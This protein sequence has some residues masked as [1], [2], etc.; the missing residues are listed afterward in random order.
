MIV[1]W[2]GV[3]ERE[4]KCAGLSS[5]LH[6]QS[7]TGSNIALGG[8]KGEIWIDPAKL[9]K[10]P[11]KRCRLCGVKEARNKQNGKSNILRFGETCKKCR[12]FDR[13]QV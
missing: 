6:Q 8:K 3:L 4:G 11:L 1:V 10:R 7:I 5:P 12:G 9:R 13:P 2:S